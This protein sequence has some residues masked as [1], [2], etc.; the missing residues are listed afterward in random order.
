[1]N[2]YGLFAGE[3]TGETANMWG[4]PADL[5]LPN[6]GMLIQASTLR[7]QMEDPRDDRQF[8]APTSPSD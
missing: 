2:T 7:W 8:R 1:M 4:D 3:P 6:S 5:K